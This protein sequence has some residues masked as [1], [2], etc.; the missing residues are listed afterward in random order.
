M[1]F[2]NNKTLIYQSLK[3]EQ[4]AQTQG[5]SV[6]LKNKSITD[7][8]YKGERA[9]RTGAGPSVIRRMCVRSFSD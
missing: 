7:Y 8:L 6:K 3:T 9:Q 4:I 2:H 1:C 5:S